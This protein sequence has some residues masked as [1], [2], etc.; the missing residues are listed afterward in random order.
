MLA[1]WVGIVAGGELSSVCFC[2]FMHI[3]ITVGLVSSYCFYLYI[4]VGII[5]RLAYP[6]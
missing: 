1:A 6:Y 2:V 3:V 4:H 5:F